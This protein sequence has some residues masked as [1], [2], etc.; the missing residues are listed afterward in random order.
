MFSRLARA[1]ILVVGLM[2]IALASAT[3]SAG[4]TA[5][6][7]PS[8]A[9]ARSI[10]LYGSYQNPAGWGWTPSNISNSLTLTVNKGDVITFH[11]YANDSMLHQ[12]LID[13]DN[14]HSNTTGDSWSPMFSNKTTAK[15]WQYT[16]STAGTFAF[17]CNVHGYAAQHGTLVVQAPS[18]G[19]G[20][21]TTDMT[22]LAIGGIVIVVAIVA[23]VAAVMLRRKRP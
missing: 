17:F 14:S 18:G 13:L 1:S 23:I 22:T 2:V 21:T 8:A 20:G 10:T 4:A 6:P 15:D 19:G 9:S 7:G 16:A 11:L 12:L 3:L 5:S